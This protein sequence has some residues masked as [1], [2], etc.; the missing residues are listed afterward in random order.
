MQ[1]FLLSII[2][3]LVAIVVHQGKE[4]RELER[5]TL[6]AFRVVCQKIRD[7]D[8]ICRSYFEKKY[9]DIP[10]TKITIKET[11]LWKQQKYTVTKKK[12]I[13]GFAMLIPWFSEVE[14]M[15]IWGF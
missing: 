1:I 6:E 14:F 11:Q 13:A 15:G 10:E 3:I 8:Q 7:D 4:I 5:K 12:Y 9:A 2:L